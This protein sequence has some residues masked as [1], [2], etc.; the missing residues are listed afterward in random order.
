MR[1]VIYKRVSTAIQVSDGVSL[2][3][4]E[5][6][7][8]AYCV[9]QG[10][11]LVCVYE[12]AGMSGKE[13]ASRIAYQQ[14]MKDAA[15]NKF[16]CIVVY[17]LDRLTR[18]VKD[19]HEL[20]EKLD[21][22][23]VNIVSVTQ[24]LDTSTAVGR[25]LRNILVDF[26]NF[27]REMILERTMDVKYSLAEKGQWLGGKAPFGYKVVNK[28]LVLVE[29]QAKVVKE[30]F[31]LYLKG[32]SIMQIAKKLMGGYKYKIAFIL[33]NP[34]YTGY[35][36][37]S[38]TCQNKKGQKQRKPSDK[39]IMAQGEHEAIISL[40]DWNQ[41]QS[42]RKSNYRNPGSRTKAQIFENLCWCECGE[43]IYYYSNPNPK[44]C[45]YI[46][47]DR[48]R[49]NNGCQISIREDRLEKYIIDRFIEISKD[50]LYWSSLEKQINRGNVTDHKK[51]IKRLESDLNVTTKAISNLI[52]QMSSEGA[53]E[54]AYLIAPEIKKLET[55][56]KE[57]AELI[58]EK[59]SESFNRV[60]VVNMKNQITNLVRYWNNADKGEKRELITVVLERITI[61]RNSI[62]IKFVDPNIPVL[63]IEFS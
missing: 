12:D 58:Q 4:Q 6:K 62:D 35:L 38:R 22:Y 30:I 19:F 63:L 59:Q 45:Y 3:H 39:W 61:H 55:K 28:K 10:W 9:V 40:D 46:C 16:D 51:E 25:L 34:V 36:G 5:E 20:I 24:N 15:E 14:M 26:A 29:D 31:E 56:K 21:I 1:A 54:I 32:N 49:I 43:R 23:K 13:T 8:K 17:K 18:S 52:Y 42:M 57:I 60:T 50:K 47:N 27:E 11:E 41:V 2:E 44:Y 7:L 48:N 37:Y 33:N 53:K